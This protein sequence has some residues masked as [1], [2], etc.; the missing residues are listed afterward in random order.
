MSTT[1]AMPVRATPLAVDVYGCGRVGTAL[2]PKLAQAGIPVASLHDSQGVRTASPLSGVRRVLVD[3]TNP[4]YTGPAAREW[5]AVLQRHLENGT[6]I[7]TCNKAPLATHGAR[8]QAAARHGGTAIWSSATVGAGTPILLFLSRLQECHGLSSVEACL[9]GTL[10]YVLHRVAAG[11]SLAEATRQ[12]QIA[13]YAE[14]NPQVDLDGID[15]YAKAVILHNRL[16]PQSPAKSLKD[17]E[18]RLILD[19]AFIRSC[20]ADGL[21]PEVVARLS[22]GSISL[23]LEGLPPGRALP[24][25]PATAA[26]RATTV[27]GFVF[28]ASG[29]GAGA[30]STASA[31]V[32][33]LLD[34]IDR[35]VP[36]GRRVLP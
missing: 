36:A 32:G 20:R 19:E 27:D 26:V 18:D 15:A 9:S 12:A 1:L 16:W 11:S 23:A 6:P 35:G 22:P 25:S 28:E 29:P 21:V 10:A 4:K 13:G 5:V 14:P 8:L 31:V 24:A 7:V 17:R 30:E 33:D 34:I 2:L 3:V